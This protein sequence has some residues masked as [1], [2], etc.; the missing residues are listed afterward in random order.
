[1]IIAINKPKGI[2]SH[3]VVC[4][5]RRITKIKIVGHG[6]TLDPFAA[7]VLIVGIERDST[8]KLGEI[9][10]FKKEYLAEV[11]L[12]I[13]TDTYD[14]TGKVTEM[15]SQSYSI[16]DE[17]DRPFI[18]GVL[19]KFKG[20]QE[21][22]PPIYSAKKIKGK[23]AYELARKGKV[24]ELKPKEI[25]VF[26]IRLAKADFENNTL[27][28]RFEVSSGTYIRSLAH[29]VGRELGC[30]A[31]LTELTRTKVGDWTLE[32]AMSLEEFKTCWQ[33][34]NQLIKTQLYDIITWG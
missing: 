33:N 22:M 12:G 15:H 24:P 10:G 20:K 32:N 23:K 16:Y 27:T 26:D 28:V 5:V 6:G 8:K 21:Q 19:N 9:T 3:D 29:D 17:K 30:G 14:R 11:K 31:H 13:E 34:R 18:E 2:T 7:G 4:A 1:M 25:E